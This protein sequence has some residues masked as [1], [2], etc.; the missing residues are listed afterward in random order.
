MTIPNETLLA[1]K[2]TNSNSDHQLLRYCKTNGTL[3]FTT[4]YFPTER[5][6]QVHILQLRDFEV[7]G[8]TKFG[9]N[10]WVSVYLDPGKQQKTET[11]SQIGDVPFFNE[12][13]QFKE[14]DEFHIQ[15]CRLV[16][17]V[18][19]KHRKK[20][21]KELL[22]VINMDLGMIGTTGRVEKETHLA[23]LYNL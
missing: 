3:E 4:Q 1:T 13:L 5:L 10:A 17:K 23:P 15:Q 11:N 2:T 7:K 20:H 18:Y 6:F 21:A 14:M 12:K 9:L 8:D 22:G 19:N 16:L